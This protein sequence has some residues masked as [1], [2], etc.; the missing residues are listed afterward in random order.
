ME[1]EEKKIGFAKYK[2]QFSMGG[3]DFE[4]F[5]K[6]LSEADK[7]GV[8]VWNGWDGAI[9]PYFSLLKQFYKNIRMIVGERE[10]IDKMCER[11]GN[12]IDLFVA[13]KNKG[14]NYGYILKDILKDLEKFSDKIYEMKQWCGLGIEINKVMSLKKRWEQA[15]GI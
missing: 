8:L 12:K 1:I 5:H 10:E 15:A 7:Y 4:R 3:Y 9:K 11:L 2:S 13:Y 6:I 14:K